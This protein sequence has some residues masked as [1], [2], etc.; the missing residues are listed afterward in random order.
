MAKELEFWIMHQ[1]INIFLVSGKA[2]IQANDLMSL[3][4]EAFTQMRAKEA[5][6][7][8]NQNCFCADPSHSMSF[9]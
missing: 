1:M 2:I 5:G 8:G 7:S 4:Q 9:T 6:S 3:L